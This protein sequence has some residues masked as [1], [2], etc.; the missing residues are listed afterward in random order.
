MDTVARLIADRLEPAFGQPVVVDNR[1]GAS[2]NIASALVASAPPDGCTLLVA[3]TALAVLPSTL[4]EQAVD[5]LRALTPVTKIATQPVL[6]AAHPTLPATT[7]ADVI[8]LAR[9]SPGML[10]YATSGIATAD[11]LAAVVLT[12]RADVD[13]LHVPYVNIG[14]EMK[15]LLHGEVKLAFMLTG[16]AQPHLEAGTL[17]A[18]AVT[19]LRRLPALPDIPTVAESGYPGYEIVS[20]YG[21]LAPAGTPAAVV[22]RIQREVA[23]ILRQGDVAAAFAAKSLQPVGNTPAQFRAELTELIAFWRPVAK[24][25]GIAPK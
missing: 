12:Q 21:L 23:A 20:W 9:K 25:A 13:M 15:D 6:I 19:G 10:A 2:G 8:A 1:P 18:I 14:Q 4:P 11:H 7:L 22:D 3:A 16:S 17:K 24:A 5:P